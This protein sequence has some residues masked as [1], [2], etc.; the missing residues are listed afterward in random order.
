MRE[1][2]VSKDWL[3]ALVNCIL[4]RM[5]QGTIPAEPV[6]LSLG[7]PWFLSDSPGVSLPFTRTGSGSARR[8]AGL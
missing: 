4:C 6:H 5:S 1:Q 7:S 3:K 8:S 2:I